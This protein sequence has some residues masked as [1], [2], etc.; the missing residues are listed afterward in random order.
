MGAGKTT[1]IQDVL[2]R[3][4]L[5]GGSGMS[6]NSILGSV[7]QSES[8]FKSDSINFAVKDISKK[9]HSQSFDDDAILT[10][11]VSFSALTN[12]SKPK[13]ALQSKLVKRGRDAFGTRHGEKVSIISCCA[14]LPMMKSIDIFLYPEVYNY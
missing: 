8:S 7:F 2:R 14:D 13:S 5:P 3:L 4:S 10:S 6:S 9:R 11:S 1:L 12:T